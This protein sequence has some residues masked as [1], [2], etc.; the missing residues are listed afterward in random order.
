MLVNL[1]FRDDF[2]FY[3]TSFSID[4]TETIGSFVDAEELCLTEHN[5]KRGINRILPSQFLINKK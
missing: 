2:Y 1:V 5:F 3:S 4:S